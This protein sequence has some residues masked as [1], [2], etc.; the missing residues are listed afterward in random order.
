MNFYVL[1]PLY[2]AM[3]I[4]NDVVSIKIIVLLR[5]DI[6]L[7]FTNNIQ[8]LHDIALS[9]TNIV[10]TIEINVVLSHYNV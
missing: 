10:V 4:A 2:N 5:T 3:S 9:I 7:L 6:L 8:L 1:L